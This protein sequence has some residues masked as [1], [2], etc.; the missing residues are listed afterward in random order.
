M[1][2]ICCPASPDFLF[3]RR[4]TCVSK[5]GISPNPSGRQ[6]LG[7]DNLFYKQNGKPS[8]SPGIAGGFTQ[9]S[10]TV[11]IGLLALAITNK[12]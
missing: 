10:P 4:H 11:K 6:T 1:P 7:D 5:S 9:K 3:V 12:N 8:L 2:E